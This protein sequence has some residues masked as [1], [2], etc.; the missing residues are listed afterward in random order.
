MFNAFIQRSLTN[1]LTKFGTVS[2]TQ[3]RERVAR[4][5]PLKIGGENLSNHN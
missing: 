2:Y 4:G 3:L 1:F 5:R